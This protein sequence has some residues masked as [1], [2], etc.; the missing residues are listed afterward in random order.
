[1]D[2]RG[3][4]TCQKQPQVRMPGAGANGDLDGL[5]THDGFW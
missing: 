5:K 4:T 1:M 2:N 3:N